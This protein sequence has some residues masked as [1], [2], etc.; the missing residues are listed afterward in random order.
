MYVCVCVQS[1]REQCDLTETRGTE[2]SRVG[3]L[4][5]GVNGQNGLERLEEVNWDIELWSDRT[6]NMYCTRMLYCNT[7][8]SARGEGDRNATAGEMSG[9]KSRMEVRREELRSYERERR[10]ED[11]ELVGCEESAGAR[12]A[13]SLN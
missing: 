5:R 9:E 2:R 12:L 4:M 1:K 13:D 11:S 3:M 10:G 8:Q 7:P 6:K